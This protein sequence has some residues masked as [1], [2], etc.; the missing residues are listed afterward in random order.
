M[1]IIKISELPA[2][3][4]PVSPADVV[5]ALQN[6][7]TKKAA[8]NQFGFDAAGSTAVTRTIQ[9][10]LRDVVSVK[11]FGAI[12]DGVADDTAA[13]QAAINAAPVVY[14][15]A[16][17]YLISAPINVGTTGT[18]GNKKIY[19]AGPR[20][21][22]IKANHSTATLQNKQSHYFIEFADF[23][24][25]G[26]NVATVGISL[27]IPSGGT[28]SAAYDT[29]TN[30]HI[31]N[32]VSNALELNSIQY[33]DVN[34]CFIAGTSAGYGVHAE[35]LLTSTISDTVIID[36]QYGMY[37]GNH[38]GALSGSAIVYLNRLEFFGPYGS[39][40]PGYYLRFDGAYDVF[41]TE[42]T[43]EN[44]QVFPNALVQIDNSN[45][46]LVTGNIF[47]N[48]C[49]WQGLPYAQDLI[50]NAGGTRIF[51]NDCVAIRPSPG[52]YILKSTAGAPTVVGITNCF[53][54]TG[55]TSY[56]TLY[57][58]DNGF[59]SAAAETLWEQR[60][61]DTVYY[62]DYT[63]N[64]AGIKIRDPAFG[65]DHGEP[66]PTTGTIARHY[67]GTYTDRTLA[68]SFQIKVET[69][70]TNANRG[71]QANLNGTT[72]NLYP[73]GYSAGAYSP[74]GDTTIDIGYTTSIV[75]TGKLRPRT[76]NT[77]NLGDASFRW[78]E[79]YAVAPAINTSDANEKQQVRD[80]SATEQAVAVDLKKLVKAF[81][82][83]DAVE[84]KGDNAR[85]HFGVI[86][87]DVHA[88][89][90]KHG[91]DASHYG[92]FCSDTWYEY[93]GK[94]VEVNEHK[95]FVDKY[96]IDKDGNR[97]EHVEGVPTPEGCTDVVDVHDTVERTRLGVRYN[98]LIAFIIS[99]L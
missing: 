79:V 43:F 45:G 47:F 50:E 28:G 22:T 63:N 60:T 38:G 66:S 76:D 15:P 4:S 44:E 24:F 17:T 84:K 93:N 87:Q 64:R 86:A 54:K 91:L 2:A 51:F 83:N 82:W 11:D 26:N 77:Y 12:G 95:K 99:A 55:Y 59:T 57:W 37:I 53:A 14:I 9:S 13:I 92:L 61:A 18:I 80:L 98:E 65:F 70:T 69:T 27:G 7:V 35:K 46:S 74:V 97:G 1:A 94:V 78:A 21:T 40:P 3:T 39:I 8:I 72:I 89:F 5:P 30:V 56:P 75:S 29:L 49:I 90:A 42:C 6:G 88:A 33:V 52:S 81:K 48:G 73:I 32:C 10:K 62:N 96:W 16:G 31:I 58:T 67:G 34:G 71:L 25:D 23:R 41:V 19:G 85:W 68:P 20:S 36:N